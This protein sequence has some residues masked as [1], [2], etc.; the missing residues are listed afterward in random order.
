MLINLDIMLRKLHEIIKKKMLN[1]TADARA[2]REG[3]HAARL[4]AVFE[5]NVY[6][7]IHEHAYQRE[8]AARALRSHSG[9]FAAALASLNFRWRHGS[10]IKRYNSAAFSVNQFPTWIAKDMA[11]ML[12]GRAVLDP[13]AG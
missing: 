6:L 10:C 9:D 7:L 5:H 13:C 4:A 2:A 11:S 3:R 12:G 1:G 8:P